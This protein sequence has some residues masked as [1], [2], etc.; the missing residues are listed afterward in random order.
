MQCYMWAFLAYCGRK[1]SGARLTNYVLDILSI[2]KQA[3]APCLKIIG[4]WLEALMFFR[5]V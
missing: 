1:Y 4:I 2:R 5:Y 3:L